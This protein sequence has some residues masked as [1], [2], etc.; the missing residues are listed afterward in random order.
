MSEEWNEYFTAFTEGDEAGQVDGLLDI[1]VVAWGTLLQRYGPHT[2]ELLA[3]EVARSNF[4]KLIGGVRRDSTG[5][6]LKPIGW[7][8]PRIAEI[9]SVLNAEEP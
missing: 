4:D 6:V 8:P 5:R 3:A 7:T 1:I 9:L 2:T